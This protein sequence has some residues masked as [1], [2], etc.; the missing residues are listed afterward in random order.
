MGH[1]GVLQAVIHSQLGN[2]CC[3]GKVGVVSPACPLSS[4]IFQGF[5]K[6]GLGQSVLIDAFIFKVVFCLL[7]VVLVLLCAEL[8]AWVPFE[9]HLHTFKGQCKS[10]DSARTGT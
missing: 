6:L 5:L 10:R 8:L 9:T 4:L 1:R 7:Q 2:G 3:V